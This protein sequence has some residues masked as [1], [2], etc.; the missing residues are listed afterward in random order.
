MRPARPRLLRGSA[1]IFAWVFVVGLA[2]GC[3]SAEVSRALGAKCDEKAEC[4]ERC[5]PP[6]ELSPGGF[7]TLSCLDGGDCPAGSVC[8]DVE[9]GVCLFA[10][11][12][13]RNC[14][15]LGEDWECDD[16]ISL[17]EGSE[18]VRGCLGSDA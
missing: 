8:A 14:E 7:C 5:M 3:P 16:R 12:V 6:S 10:C 17:P 4:D 13:D 18:E 11:E 2:A 15:F 1:A 9:G